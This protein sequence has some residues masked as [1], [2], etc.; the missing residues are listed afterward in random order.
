MRIRRTILA[1]V[2]LALGTVG[3]LVAGPVLAVTAAA[4]P[5][6]AA[7]AVGPTAPAVTYYHG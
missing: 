4:A 7:V 3:A 1:P 6:A 2:V 5:A